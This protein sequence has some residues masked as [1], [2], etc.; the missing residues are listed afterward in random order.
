MRKELNPA[1]EEVRAAAEGVFP[2]DKGV[3]AAAQEAAAPCEGV[4]AHPARQ[5]DIFFAVPLRLENNA[6]TRRESARA[7]NKEGL[8]MNDYQRRPA[9]FCSVAEVR[10]AQRT[11]AASAL[12]RHCAGGGGCDLLGQG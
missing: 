7:H 3:S 12:P 5:Q 6:R 1:G 8:A 9:C 10:R 11:A 2:A 4:F